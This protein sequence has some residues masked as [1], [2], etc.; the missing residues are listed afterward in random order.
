MQNA[1]RN[2]LTW[3]LLLLTAWACL[4]APPCGAKTASGNFDGVESASSKMTGWE[5][6]PRLGFGDLAGKSAS[7]SLVGANSAAAN[8]SGAVAKYGPLN[9]GPLTTDFANTFRSGTYT[10]VVTQQPT[11]LY[12]VY[13]G[14]A[15][16]LGS[17]WTTTPP[18]GSVQ[19]IIDS[20]LNPQWSNTATNVVRIEVPSGTNFYQGIAAPQ[21]G[22]V[23][24][25]NQVLFPPGFRVDPAW[26]KMP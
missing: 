18:A 10:E 21:G 13:G 15:G 16:E 14:S 2:P 9:P 23:G 4:A 20:A 7:V 8:V 3:L 12:R 22:L 1:T 26:I 25:G 24:G 19:S 6:P 11:T 17:Y 5:A